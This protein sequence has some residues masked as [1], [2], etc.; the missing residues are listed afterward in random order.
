MR[1]TIDM[2]IHI[3]QKLSQE[4]AVRNLKG[5]SKIIIEALEKYFH[6]KSNDR[7]NIV[8]RLKGSMS[9]AEHSKA[10]KNLQEGR[11]KWRI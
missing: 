11:S 10:V 9:N 6:S 5:F 4:A 3:R 8:T 2:P 7:K 1:T